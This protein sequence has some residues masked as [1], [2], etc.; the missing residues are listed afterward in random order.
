MTTEGTTAPA[1]ADQGGEQAPDLSVWNDQ[2]RDAILS[3][4]GNDPNSLAKGY[5]NSQQA[6]AKRDTES[7]DIANERADF[8][9]QRQEWEAERKQF[10]TQLEATKEGPTPAQVN[11]NVYE[12]VQSDLIAHNEV[13]EETIKALTELGFDKEFLTNHVKNVSADL[14][15]RFASAQEHTSQDTDVKELLKFV[16]EDAAKTEDALFT[17][18]ELEY[19]QDA[20]NRGDYGFVKQVEAKYLVAQEAAGAKAAKAPKVP[21]QTAKGH[22]TSG[23]QFATVEEYQKAKSD[24]KYMIDYEYRREVDGKYSRSDQTAFADQQMER[25]FGSNWDLGNSAIRNG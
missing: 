14:N 18:A 13:Q 17:A 15:D 1:G 20:A 6:F 5:F 16:N 11:Q 21:G 2:T 22:A 25:M 8:V 19:F 24:P 12:L 23:T 7:Q 9:Q 10:S 3:K 4:Y